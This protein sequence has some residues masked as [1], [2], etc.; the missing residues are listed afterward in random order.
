M[1]P[2]FEMHPEIDCP[3][4]RVGFGVI[5]ANLTKPDLKWFMSK[6]KKKKLI[7]DAKE[8]ATF[9]HLDLFWSYESGLIT[10]CKNADVLIKNIDSIDDN[11]NVK[12]TSE[13]EQKLKELKE[14]Y[15]IKPDDITKETCDWKSF[16]TLF[17]NA[18]NWGMIDGD[19]EEFDRE[20]MKW[21]DIEKMYNEGKNLYDILR[22]YVVETKE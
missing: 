16:N 5:K 21:E 4:C 10:D 19:D 11:G 7:S 22:F 8:K 15:D 14:K 12:F 2:K 6:S 3:Y 20:S 9:Q 18:L 17:I 1:N 13:F